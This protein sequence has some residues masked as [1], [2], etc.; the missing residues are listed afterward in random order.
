[1]SPERQHSF[2]FVGERLCGENC[3]WPATRH[4]IPKTVYL[5]QVSVLSILSCRTRQTKYTKEIRRTR[6]LPTR[7]E[8]GSGHLF[9]SPLLFTDAR[10]TEGLQHQM[11]L[12]Q[13]S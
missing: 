8:M 2:Y 4:E 9:I 5:V 1:M 13:S 6:S 7:R 12:G 11:W 3:E 10:S